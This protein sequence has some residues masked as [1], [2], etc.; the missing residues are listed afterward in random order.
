M[1]A[2]CKKHGW[3]YWG[4]LVGVS[5]IQLAVLTIWA[6][7]TSYFIVLYFPLSLNT[8]MSIEAECGMIY[9]DLIHD[10]PFIETG[11][12]YVWLEREI[13]L[14]SLFRW[15]Y[16]F[17]RSDIFLVADLY[18]PLWFLFLLL[19]LW[20]AIAIYHWIFRKHL[21]GFCS[22]CNYDLRGSPSGVCPECG[23]D[24]A[25]FGKVTKAM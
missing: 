23:E 10:E 6:L 22:A 2:V 25:S 16:G 13:D 18:F 24:T 21:V 19:S 7:S 11:F 12:H 1:K 3:V 20:P 8:Y 15:E 17:N 4:S 14:S 9:F 5:T